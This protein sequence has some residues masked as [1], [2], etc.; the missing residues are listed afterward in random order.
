MLLSDILK[1]DNN[2]IDLIRIIAAAMVI[3]GHS[4]EISP[5]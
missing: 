4:Y 5:R 1:K 2:N 3:Y